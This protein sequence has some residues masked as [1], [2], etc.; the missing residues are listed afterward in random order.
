MSK[1]EL[2][3]LQEYF[4]VILKKGFIHRSELPA[5]FLVLFIL[6]KN[7]K[8]QLYINFRKHNN[9]TVKN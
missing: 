7:R 2:E 9:I 3:A 4:K 1:K 6:K 8:L 5:G